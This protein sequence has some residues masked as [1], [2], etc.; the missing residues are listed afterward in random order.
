L[1][2]ELALLSENARAVRLVRAALFLYLGTLPR[3]FCELGGYVDDLL[4]VLALD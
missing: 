2:A 4:M 1:Q 3:R